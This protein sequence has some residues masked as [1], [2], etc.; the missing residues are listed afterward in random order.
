MSTT[1]FG[2]FEK[3]LRI[4]EGRRVKRLKQQAAFIATLEPEF[5]A[6]SDDELRAKTAEFR[7]RL[8][9]ETLEEL[10]FEAFA[11]IREARWRESAQRMFDVQ[12][13]GG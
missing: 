4:G 5:Q 9:N 8:E 3:V 1:D 12:M 2:K 13:M 6:L 10:L 7:Q 11:A